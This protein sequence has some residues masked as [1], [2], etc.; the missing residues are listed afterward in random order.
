MVLLRIILSLSFSGLSTAY[1]T[2]F[3][4]VQKEYMYISIGMQ[5]LLGCGTISFRYTCIMVHPTFAD[6]WTAPILA[7]ASM[8]A[9]AR[10]MAGM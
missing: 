10:G 6:L 4:Y 9:T 8:E 1:T 5:V 2:L 7:Q 3:V